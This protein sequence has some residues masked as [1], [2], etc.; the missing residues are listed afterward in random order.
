MATQEIS[1]TSTMT[2]DCKKE[3]STNTTLTRTS[4]KE[5]TS[6]TTYWTRK[7]E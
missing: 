4:R 2:W 3:I 6:N 7:Q 5:T 1:N